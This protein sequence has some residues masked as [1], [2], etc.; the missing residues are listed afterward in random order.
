MYFFLFFVRIQFTISAFCVW[1]LAHSTSSNTFL[2]FWNTQFLIIILYFMYLG[3]IVKLLREI[4]MKYYFS[5][6]SF[7]VAILNRNINICS[8]NFWNQ[9]HFFFVKIIFIFR[10]TKT[11]NEKVLKIIIVEAM[12]YMIYMFQNVLFGE[13]FNWKW[14]LIPSVLFV[15]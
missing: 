6:F 3:T 13:V 11:W 1:Q 12:Y 4:N 14:A 15:K 9:N 10:K 8:F 2:K 5:R 7:Y